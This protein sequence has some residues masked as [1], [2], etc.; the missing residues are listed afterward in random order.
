MSL[1]ITP[2]LWKHSSFHYA[3]L[4]RPQF[5]DDI[6]KLTNGMFLIQKEETAS[7]LII[8]P[9]IGLL[10]FNLCNNKFNEA[11]IMMLPHI[12]IYIYIA[13]LIHEKRKLAG[14]QLRPTPLSFPNS[15]RIKW[16]TIAIASD[17]DLLLGVGILL[18]W[19]YHYLLALCAA[20]VY[21]HGGPYSEA[22]HHPNHRISNFNHSSRRA[23]ISKIN[24]SCVCFNTINMNC[25]RRKR[26]RMWCF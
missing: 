13:V 1:V 25:S 5:L 4:G 17:L 2:H 9:K 24:K 22:H 19:H 16:P 6:V 15:E 7:Y 8:L 3:W 10:Q 26:C 18:C 23:I 12:Y 20:C 21:V 11:Y 14:S